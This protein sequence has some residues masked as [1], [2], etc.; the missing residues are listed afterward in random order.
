MRSLRYQA[1]LFH[2]DVSYFKRRDGQLIRDVNDYY[3]TVK[4]ENRIWT[5]HGIVKED[6]SDP[7][8]YG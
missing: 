1:T 4:A 6:R 5:P 2:V 3:S 8:L 7:R